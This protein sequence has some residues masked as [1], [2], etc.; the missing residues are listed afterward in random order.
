[1]LL[2]LAIALIILHVASVLSL[3]KVVPHLSRNV[4]LV[5]EA[6][7]MLSLLF[8]ILLILLLFDT[9]H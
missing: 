9:I 8:L 3:V 5:L 6:A 2:L 1:M 4:L 7:L